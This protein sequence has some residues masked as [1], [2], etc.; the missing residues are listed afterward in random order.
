ML[1]CIIMLT[2]EFILTIRFQTNRF[3]SGNV[4]I[5]S[6]GPAQAGTMRELPKAC[7]S[8]GCDLEPHDYSDRDQIMGNY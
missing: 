6:T 8:Q 7:N 3:K 1:T 5:P 2:A 4:A